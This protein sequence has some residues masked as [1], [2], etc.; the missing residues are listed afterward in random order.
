[1]P[2]PAHGSDNNG[3]PQPPAS[4]K[5]PVDTVATLKSAQTLITVSTIAGP[6]S[7]IIGG[8]LLSVIALICGLM[9]WF[10]INKVSSKDAERGTLAYSLRRQ[11]MVVTAISA[12][13]LGVNAAWLAYSVPALI[14]A[15]E[16][17]SLDQ[18]FNAASSSAS[19]SSSFW[20]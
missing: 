19:S 8:V 13:V 14:E 5:Q 20:G 2:E 16:S 3:A 17:G 1:M 11:A 6:V 18:Y 10:K 12:L 15:L 7:L 4:N 9:A